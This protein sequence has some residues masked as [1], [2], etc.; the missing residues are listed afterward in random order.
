MSL[1]IAFISLIVLAIGVYA[2][3]TVWK[4]RAL[5]SPGFYFSVIWGLGII[6][7]IIFKSLG[8][9]VEYIPKHIDE[10]NI[11]VAFT[12]FCFT[13]FVKRGRNRVS[14]E[15]SI[16]IE[17]ISSTQL[18]K[19]LSVF[20]LLLSVYVFF[21]EGSG[22]DFA[23][24]RD[25]MHTTIENRSFLVGYFRILSV[26]LAIYAGSRLVKLLSHSK[27]VSITTY[28]YLMLPF[29]AD[30]LFSFTEGG[31]VA[32]VYSML[33]YVVGGAISLPINFNFKLYKK[34]LLNAVIF[35]IMLNV[36]ISWIGSIRADKYDDKVNLVKKELGPMSF[37]YGS[38][39]YIQTSYLG[40]QYRRD[41]AVDLNNLGYG[42]YTFNGFINWELPFSARFGLENSS[43]AHLLGIY[44]HNQETYDFTR[45]YYYVTHSAYIPIIKDFGFKGAFIAIFFIVFI[46]HSLFIKIQKRNEIKYATTFFFFYLFFDYWSRSNF[47]GS[48]SSSILIP[49]YSFLLIDIINFI[50]H[51]KIR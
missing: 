6:G 10:L 21:T 17:F 27:R 13:L 7:V 35:I 16:N 5:M 37:L 46:A 19:I 49:L 30:T 32:M 43:I 29:L 51:N 15:V 34:V 31:R 38:I 41:D 40:Y 50:T 42:K 12:S 48:L 39:S 24:A 3:L 26:P 1:T 44:Y 8:I 25:S 20:Y 36:I 22:L 9:L 2:Q 11:L 47:Y 28:I 23:T 33:M 18:F 45:D 14:S 4:A